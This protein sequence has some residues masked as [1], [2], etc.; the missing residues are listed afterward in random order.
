MSSW[1]RHYPSA[2]SLNSSL[3][4]FTLNATSL[5]KNSDADYI[6]EECDRAK[7]ERRHRYQQN[8]PRVP[9]SPARL[10]SSTKVSNELLS[11]KSEVTSSLSPSP[12][13]QPLPP[14]SPRKSS[15]PVPFSSS[16]PSTAPTLED[17]R[18]FITSLPP[19]EILRTPQL[20]PELEPQVPPIPPELKGYFTK[21]LFKKYPERTEELR[22]ERLDS[23]KSQSSRG[24]LES[25]SFVPSLQIPHP[26]P[27]PFLLDSSVF[28]GLSTGRIDRINE[29]N[30]EKS[31][32]Q[33]VENAIIE[34][35]LETLSRCQTSRSIEK[36][37]QDD[38]SKRQLQRNS[39]A[40]IKAE[41]WS[42]FVSN[43]T[44]IPP[45]PPTPEF[46]Y[47]RTA[48]GLSRN[49][50][51]L[52]VQGR[53]AEDP[54]KL[55]RGP[56]S[57]ELL[58]HKEEKEEERVEDDGSMIGVDT[59]QSLVVDESNLTSFS[60]KKQAKI[61]RKEGDTFLSPY[62]NVFTLKQRPMSS[63][64]N[65]SQS[66]LHDMGH[67][68]DLPAEHE[69]DVTRPF[70]APNPTRPKSGTK[71]SA[72]KSAPV[73]K[74]GA[75][76]TGKGQKVDGKKSQSKPL[77]ETIKLRGL[78]TPRPGFLSRNE[79]SSNSPFPCTPDL[80]ELLSIQRKSMKANEKGKKGSDTTKKQSKP[81][82]KGQ[83]ATPEP[84]VAD[85]FDTR[86]FLSSHI[87]P[88][89]PRPEP[90]SQVNLKNLGLIQKI[91]ELNSEEVIIPEESLKK[92]LLFPEDRPY[93]DCLLN[94]PA[95]GC[96]LPSNPTKK[97]KEKKGKKKKK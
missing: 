32:E 56:L 14:T 6:D 75:K 74:K 77:T 29:E 28:T 5:G 49:P 87:P 12:F 67:Y 93:S 23:L 38:Y 41:S 27:S 39:S 85:T 55:L 62:A 82:G 86:S 40:Y 4:S 50:I 1:A 52:D 34:S 92:V 17:Y 21:D 60:L 89:P 53:P 91:Q 16:R 37:E 59:M 95:P 80:V 96:R 35:R 70:T 64:S 84:V 15:S 22:Q 57:T 46:A 78:M 42:C 65:K 2:Q 7:L 9:I 11:R 47:R 10:D 81:A 26:N 54:I 30:E 88:I 66:I 61:F 24:R 33:K 48:L 44:R 19:L 68:S 3:S 71:N 51:P 90:S 79:A 31:I 45:I 69:L 83:K 97:K 36:R 20:P 63:Y 8:R 58:S 72:K 94:L 73:D 25:S 76:P 43:Y 18:H 13:P